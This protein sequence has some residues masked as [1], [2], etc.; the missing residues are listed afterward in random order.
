MW[1]TLRTAIIDKLKEPTVTKIAEAHRT[2]LSSFSNYP[3]AVVV[4]T[5]KQSDYHSTQQDRK[6]YAYTVVIY[7]P[8]TF[9]QD[10]ADIELEKA[11]DQLESIFSD[12]NVLGSACLW[13]EP[14][15][16]RWGYVKTS[17]NEHRVAELVLKCVVQ[18]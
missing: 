13:V 1:H 11:V 17:K 4:P 3:A 8:F 14:V 12:R 10:D 6:V 18:N 5:D 15:V 9:G 16:S 7:Y 2:D